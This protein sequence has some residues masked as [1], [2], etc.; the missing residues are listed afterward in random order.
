MK[1]RFLGKP[2][3]VFTNQ[4]NGFKRDFIETTHAA[5]G[6]EHS[7]RQH[8]KKSLKNLIS[9]YVAAKEMDFLEIF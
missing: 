5:P 6:L 2:S 3:S 9:L 8:C 1:L 4:I 7:C